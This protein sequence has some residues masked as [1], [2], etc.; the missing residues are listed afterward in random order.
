MLSARTY[1]LPVTTA[2]VAAILTAACGGETYSGRAAPV[3]QPD[4]EEASDSQDGGVPAEAA[5]EETVP[6][7]A[8]Q[9]EAESP[10]PIDGGTKNPFSMS[11]H[12][13]KIAWF[14]LAD[15]DDALANVNIALRNKWYTS[16]PPVPEDNGCVFMMPDDM[17]TT[18]DPG[19]VPLNGGDVTVSGTKLGPLT[20]SPDSNDLYPILSEGQTDFFDDFAPISIQTTGSQDLP[21]LQIASEAPAKPAGLTPDITSTSFAYDGQ[22]PISLAWSPAGGTFISFFVYCAGADPFGHGYSSCWTEDTGQWTM[23]AK[24]AEAI[25]NAQCSSWVI[26]IG[27]W[28]EFE[29]YAD[30]VTSAISITSYVTS[31]QSPLSPE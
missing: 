12:P 15:S 1:L 29:Q 10:P 19:V 14:L 23:P 3:E 16:P 13:G 17:P 24:T 7:A 31:Y 22:T 25:K 20:I 30:G 11:D 6:D 5:G 4:A 2:C 28:K 27:R 8:E 18:G 21:A 9:T 26:Q